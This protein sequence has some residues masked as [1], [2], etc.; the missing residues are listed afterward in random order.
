[1]EQSKIID[2]LE[3]YQSAV[4]EVFKSLEVF[5]ALCEES[6]FIEL[7]VYSAPTPVFRIP[8]ASPEFSLSDSYG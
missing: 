3:T 2:M 4:Q 8:R 6:V 7:G 5:S 1:M